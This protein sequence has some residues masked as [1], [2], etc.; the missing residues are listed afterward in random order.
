MGIRSWQPTPPIVA[1]V[2]PIVFSRGA[3]GRAIGC[4]R[5]N[6]RASIRAGL[7]VATGEAQPTPEFPSERSSYSTPAEGNAAV[8]ALC[9]S[10]KPTTDVV[11]FRLLRVIQTDVDENRFEKWRSV[12]DTGA[13]VEEWVRELRGDHS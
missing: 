4:T 11:G 3:V 9:L 10:L 13:S 8:V 7:R 12:A 1:C 2:S 6:S 5:P